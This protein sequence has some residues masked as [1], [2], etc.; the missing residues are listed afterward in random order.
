[1]KNIIFI[2]PPAAG[3]GTQSKLVSEEYN[4]PHISTGDLLRE[5]VNK[6]TALGLEIK[7]LID[8]G[9]LVSDEVIT[10]LLTNRLQQADCNNGFI[11]DGYPRNINQAHIYE[12][13]L[14]KLGIKLGDVIF[15]DIDLETALNRIKGRL[16]CPKCGTSYNLNVKELTPQKENI[17]DKCS[18]ILS[19]REDDNEETFSKRFDIYLE[20]TNP[21]IEY[22]KSKKVLK[23]IKIDSTTTAKETFESIKKILVGKNDSN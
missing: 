22:Y 20:T 4:I 12:D 3:K 10:E 15:L 8:E 16:I 19:K 2:A 9:C 5:E 17:C 18:N 21:L 11:L 23:T 7:K 6:K 14:K 1:M 13:I